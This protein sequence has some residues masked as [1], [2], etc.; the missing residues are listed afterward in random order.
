[1]YISGSKEKDQPET[2]C[3][4]KKYFSI[5]LATPPTPPKKNRFEQNL[6]F[7]TYSRVAASKDKTCASVQGTNFQHDD[8]L[9]V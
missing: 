7:S 9:K 1:M 2:Q 3:L 4:A 6:A 5:Q 8:I